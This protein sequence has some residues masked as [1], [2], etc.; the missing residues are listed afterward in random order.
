MAGAVRRKMEQQE[1]RE[2]ILQ[3]MRNLVAHEQAVANE[4]KREAE[5]AQK[6]T[7]RKA[8]GLVKAG[9]NTINQRTTLKKEPLPWLSV[10]KKRWQGN[11]KSPSVRRN[12]GS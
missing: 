12:Q 11:L 1:Y 2:N 7:G 4:K 10:R 5:E 9:A 3:D 6:K 8:S